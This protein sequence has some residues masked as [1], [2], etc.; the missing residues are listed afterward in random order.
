MSDGSKKIR[1]N[2]KTY[3]DILYC[4]FDIQKKAKL[5]ILVNHWPSRYGGRDF[6]EQGRLTCAERLNGLADSLSKEWPDAF[7]VAIGDFNDEPNDDSILKGL[8]ANDVKNQTN[9]K[10]INLMYEYS[11]KE[12]VEQ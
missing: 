3:R 8:G 10:W 9:K 5:R 6:S 2:R 1:N 12:I 11:E 7:I 4:L